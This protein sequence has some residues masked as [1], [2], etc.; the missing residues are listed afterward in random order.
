M[1]GEVYLHEFVSWAPVGKWVASHP[2]LRHVKWSKE[3]SRTM[4]GG[5]REGLGVGV[6]VGQGGVDSV[7]IW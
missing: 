5:G 7:W 3:L 1:G 4:G 6:G 2:A